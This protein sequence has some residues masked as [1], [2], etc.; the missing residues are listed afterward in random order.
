MG[1]KKPFQGD[2]I[3]HHKGGKWQGSLLRSEN[4]KT[5]AFSPKGAAF[6]SKG[7]TAIYGQKVN[8]KRVHI[9]TRSGGLLSGMFKALFSSK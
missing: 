8:G 7:K 3:T 6:E 4:G 5:A 9:E 1:V 2:R